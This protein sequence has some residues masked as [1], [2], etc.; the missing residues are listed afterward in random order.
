[1]PSQN[2]LNFGFAGDMFE[3]WRRMLAMI[4]YE[5]LLHLFSIIDTLLVFHKMA[6]WLI[7]TI[8]IPNYGE[9]SIKGLTTRQVFVPHWFGIKRNRGFLATSEA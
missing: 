4:E 2:P 6:I 8:S 5:Q 7:S 3:E 9:V 1:L